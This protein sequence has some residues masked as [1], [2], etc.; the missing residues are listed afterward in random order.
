VLDEATNA[1]PDQG[2][3]YTTIDGFSIQA[4]DEPS[5]EV[6]RPIVEEQRL[7]R[8]QVTRDPGAPG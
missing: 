7:S 4:G 5:F 6:V 3:A 8:W 2:M 1:D